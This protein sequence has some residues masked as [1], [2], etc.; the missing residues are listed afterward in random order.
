[1]DVAGLWTPRPPSGEPT[2][3]L[4]PL[5]RALVSPSVPGVSPS[6]VYSEIYC[7]ATLPPGDHIAKLQWRPFGAQMLEWTGSRTRPG[8]RATACMYGPALSEY[9]VAVEEIH[10]PPTHARLARGHGAED[11]CHHGVRRRLPERAQE[12]PTLPTARSAL[13]R[14]TKYSSI[15]T[16]KAGTRLFC[17]CL[18][19]SVF[20]FGNGG[21]MMRTTKN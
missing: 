10:D 15:F 14:T 2:V 3:T 9:K 17:R 20:E 5:V 11:L 8:T 16:P 13:W 12:Q 7:V 19:A 6:V 1:M 18:P 4:K 21:P